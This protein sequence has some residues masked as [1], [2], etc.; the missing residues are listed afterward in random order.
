MSFDHPYCNYYIINAHSIIRY[1]IC[2]DIDV[3][4]HIYYHLQCSTTFVVLRKFCMHVNNHFT[5]LLC[6]Q[7]CGITISRSWL[8]QGLGRRGVESPKCN[9]WNCNLQLSIGSVLQ[10]SI[11]SHLTSQRCLKI[12][13]FKYPLHE[14]WDWCHKLQFWQVTSSLLSRKITVKNPPLNAFFLCL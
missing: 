9:S 10:S 11:S 3:E 5:A 1:W 8:Q 7:Q 14:C 13:A 12:G 2:I 6:C 4:S